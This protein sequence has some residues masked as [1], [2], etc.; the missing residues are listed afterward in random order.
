[1]ALSRPSR[2]VAGLTL[3]EVVVATALLAGVLGGAFSLLDTSI[4]LSQSVNDERAAAMRVDRALGAIADEFRKGSLA[5]AAH[6]DGSTFADGDTDTAFQLRPVTGWDGTAQ[7]GTQ[8][9]YSFVVP[10]GAT[11]GQL[12]RQEGALQTVLARGI[13]TFTVTRSGSSFL[14]AVTAQSG[15]ADDRRRTASGNFRVLARNP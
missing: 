1:M 13:T 8:V 4:D 5:T 14:F 6:P 3:I 11:E 7:Q 12:V 10:S 15:P 9:G 2:R